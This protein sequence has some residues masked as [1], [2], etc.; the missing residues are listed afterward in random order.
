MKK[1]FLKLMLWLL[2][3]IAFILFFIIVYKM[4]VSCSSDFN[5]LLVPLGVLIS[6]GLASVSVMTSILNTNEIEQKKNKKD[7][8]RNITYFTLSIANTFR[9]MR[10]IREILKSFLSV[11][12]LT[13]TDFKIFENHILRIQKE[14]EITQDKGVMSDIDFEILEKYYTLINM[15]EDKL[16][17]RILEKIKN[18]NELLIPSD[19]Y[20]YLV[21]NI[22]DLLSNINV[23]IRLMTTKYVEEVPS[24]NIMFSESYTYYK[25]LINNEF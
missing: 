24:V 8:N 6:A 18:K 10:D 19:E 9:Q 12:N 13:T 21:D 5:K 20:K 11:N 1:I 22:Q 17:L 16:I 14:I 7:Y 15:L 2:S 25:K 3:L 23:I 4:K